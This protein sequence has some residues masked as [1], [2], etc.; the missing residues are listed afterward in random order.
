MPRAALKNETNPRL[1]DDVADI[2][3]RGV[4]PYF[5]DMERAAALAEIDPRRLN[6][7]GAWLFTLLQDADERLRNQAAAVEEA[8]ASA[9][10]HSHD[11]GSLQEDKENLQN[12][13]KNLES[14]VKRLRAELD[15]E[16]LSAKR[17]ADDAAAETKK[18]LQVHQDRIDALVAEREGLRGQIAGI[19]NAVD[20]L[21]EKASQSQARITELES[22]E[23]LAAAFS[24]SI[25]AID[26]NKLE[27]ETL[28]LYA[29]ARLLLGMP[30]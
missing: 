4:H 17:A 3:R 7:E 8:E 18:A 26:L 30:F 1:V 27:R 22:V 23:P 14:D 5:H 29:K 2:L 15:E 19:D 25:H 11:L 21:L 9:E 24:A 12:D 28:D 6:Q 10:Q 16:A 20:A 13:V